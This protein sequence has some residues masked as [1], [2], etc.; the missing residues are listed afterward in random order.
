VADLRHELRKLER[1]EQAPLMPRALPLA[2]V[3]ALAAGGWPGPL[4]PF[5][6]QV[7]A[8]TVDCNVQESLDRR[9][10]AEAK[11]VFLETADPF[12]GTGYMLTEAEADRQ[13]A[14]H[15]PTAFAAAKAADNG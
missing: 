13:A 8:C 9:K 5:H 12:D 10:L 15:W 11:R 2:V 14:E 6:E 7:V 4:Q 3:G 1:P